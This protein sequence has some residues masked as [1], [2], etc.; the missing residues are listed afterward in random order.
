MEISPDRDLPCNRLLDY[1]FRGSVRYCS[2]EQYWGKCTLGRRRRP[3][4]LPLTLTSS[5]ALWARNR[6]ISWHDCGLAV[7]LLMAARGPADRRLPAR[8]AKARSHAMPRPA[9]AQL[10]VQV[11]PV[12]Q[13]CVPL[14]QTPLQ[15]LCYNSLSINKDGVDHCTVVILF[16]NTHTIQN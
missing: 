1:L 3:A 2:R 13:Y 10:N 15:K 4:R 6:R 11:M 7:T 9:Q 16:N 14:V 12:I 5:C 8:A